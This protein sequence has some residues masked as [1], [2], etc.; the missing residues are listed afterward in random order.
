VKCDASSLTDANPSSVIVSWGESGEVSTSTSLTAATLAVTSKERATFVVTVS[1]YANSVSGNALAMDSSGIIYVSDQSRIKKITPQGVLSGEVMT[2]SG[3]NSQGFA[4]GQGTS[5]QFYNP[6][7]IAVDSFGNLIVA[8]K[9]NKRI[10]K[11][12]PS[13]DV[14]T[15][16][17]KNEG[18]ADG[19]GTS[20]EFR[21]P[22]D[23]TIDATGNI[24]VTDNQS[25]RKISLSYE[26]ST[27]A[28]SD[29]AS[30]Y[31]DSTGT[32][33]RFNFPRGIASD[34]LG[35]VFVA[36]KGNNRIR[37]ITPSRV[38]T[39]L[40]GTGNV[41]FAD[42]AGTNAR[43]NS[44]IG[45]TFFDGYLIVS[46][47]GNCRIRKITLAGV[48]T[49]LAGRGPCGL[50]DGIGKDARF[51]DPSG[52][53]FVS[54][55]NIFVGERS[56]IRKI[57]ISTPLPVPLPVC[58]ST[59]HH[60]ALTYSG[61]SSTNTLN[62]YIDGSY[63]AY[64]TSTYAITSSDASILRLGSSGGTYSSDFFTGS[65][66]DLRI[67][68]RSLSSTEIHSLSRP[69]PQPYSAGA[70]ELLPYTW[71]CLP[72]YYGSSQITLT[73]SSSD[74]SWSSASGSL[75][76]CT[77][78]PPNT[79]NYYSGASSC[80]SCPFGSSLVSS[81]LGCRPTLSA[82]PSDTSFYLSGTETEGVASF[83]FLYTPS[84][85]SFVSNVFG[86]ANGALNLGGNSYLL[87]PGLSAPPPLP[88]TGNVEWTVS[89]WVRCSSL[90][91][92]ATIVEW[93]QIESG[94]IFAQ[95]NV[96]LIVAGVG[97]FSLSVVN[98]EV[99]SP[100]RLAVDGLGNIF[101]A[102]DNNNAI[103][104]ITPSGTF[105]I[106]D[107]GL[108]N[109]NG[110]SVDA[111][112]TVYVADTDNHAIK[113]ISVNGAVTTIGSG[114]TY[115]CGV[116]VDASGI[117]FVADT[118][119][120]AIK[121]ITSFGTTTILDIGLAYPRG[122]DV[123]LSG[124][125]YIA[126]T[127]NHAI[128]KISS[129]GTVTTLSTGFDHPYDIALDYIG[130]IYVADTY[131]HAI[132]KITASGSVTLVNTG[133]NY[134]SGID[135]DSFGNVYVAD[136]SNNA[137]K[138]CVA[139]I[140]AC[141]S[142]WHHISQSYSSS[143][144]IL[145]TSIDGDT[146][147]QKIVSVSLP[148][149]S[150]STF[151][152]GWS[153]ERFFTGSLYDLRI[154][155][156][157]LSSTEIH[158]LSRPVP[159]PY[160]AGAFE[161]LPYTWSCLPGYYGSSQITL[162]RS[163]SDGSWSSASGSLLSCTVCPPNT[164]NYYSGASSCSSCPFGSSLVS[165]TLGCR[166]T[167]S[168]GPSDTSFYLSGTETE[169]V[170]A[171][172][173]TTSSMNGISSY[174][175]SSSSS[176]PSS[177]LVFSSG[178]YLSTSMLSSLPVGSSPF[179][180]SSWVKCDASSLTDAN[181]SSV[182]VSWGESGEVST[183][184]S[185]TAATLAVTSSVRLNAATTP[186]PGPLPVCDSTWHHI[187][188][189]Y[190][191]SS[192]SSSTLTAYV[193]GAG[194]ASIS[195]TYAITSSS[196]STLRLGS[197]G[198]TTTS[199]FY[200]GTISDVRIY[201]HSLSNTEISELRLPPPTP[202]ASA[203]ATASSRPSTSS[204]PSA[205]SSASATVSVS[206]KVTPSTTVSTSSTSSVTATSTVTISASS[207]ST[208][209]ST[210]TQSMSVTPT[211]TSSGTGSASH[212]QSAT[213]SQS[214]NPTMTPSTTVSSSISVT[215]SSLT[216]STA[217]LSSQASVTAVGSSIGTSS[218]TT[219]AT[220]TAT[221]TTSGTSTRSGT[222]TATRA[223]VD[224]QSS[225][226]SPRPI[227]NVAFALSNVQ[228]SL[229]TASSE[230]SATLS[231]LATAVS[232]AAGVSSSF[233]SIR[234]VRDMTF[235]L[236]PV[237]IWINPQFAGDEFPARRRLQGG[238]SSTGSVG[239]DVQINVPNTAA[240]STLSS[241]LASTSTKLATDVH[242]SLVTQGS[243][244]SSATISAKVEVFT[245]ASK[246]DTNKSSESIS[247]TAIAYPA[248]MAFVLVAAAI[249]IGVMYCKLIRKSQS[250]IAIAPPDDNYKKS[251]NYHETEMS[252]ES[253]DS[254]DTSITSPPHRTRPSSTSPKSFQ[255]K[256]CGNCGFK[257]DQ[258]NK[259]CP[260]C[261]SMRH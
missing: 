123:D 213:H 183:S 63:K 133:L 8:D 116:K 57:T 82:G 243:P 122:V 105:S 154:Y 31:A 160:S 65:L 249:A 251:R 191:G 260:E 156:R 228:L 201:S 28:G 80:S 27:I 145:S 166:P 159:Q 67:Y 227:V 32:D 205:S 102:E 203:S 26:V 54:Q 99:S 211:M 112:G 176:F 146:V 22:I 128:K 235:P 52:L 147:S 187:A 255:Y 109:P 81:T 11:L 168:A 245:A 64:T 164:Y 40:A 165:S 190:S 151:R 181:P 68:S 53:A 223:Q 76:S 34:S 94:W 184:T 216:T 38:V 23:V 247:I 232:A 60:I 143:S 131:N 188:L 15:I 208:V 178:S 196:I 261:G 85:I 17:G 172:S 138:I 66:Y 25:I 254:E 175:P 69:V 41:G 19:S 95:R 152:V 163:S 155:S 35:N 61:S 114:F 212:S 134:P 214:T 197:N 224:L 149:L 111:I 230:Q 148:P 51:D 207:S 192:S 253:L 118:G 140:P 79:Y 259:F 186:L 185:L 115:P 89:A 39:T 174:I 119:N 10:R 210:S 240:A 96:A 221:G 14:T 101:V 136:T 153:S 73:R 219:S 141:D 189:T 58:D 37:K 83:P 7:G 103:K 47:H 33:A 238:A 30:G 59:W 248:A 233:V 45:I 142:T 46:D 252:V 18:A 108:N 225:T 246:G 5:A 4:D 257:F 236:T 43:F 173:A 150:Q 200:S 62:A 161:L 194:V 117:V 97:V 157:S 87:L 193:D 231:S 195:A 129:S 13:G 71:S 29:G 215:F 180:V 21:A 220:A 1:S 48:V 169:G 110:V 91:S 49:T 144:S 104:K 56:R 70:F 2:F 3:Q 36:D 258:S 50:A 113:V 75:L 6:H 226:P 90:S 100:R 209:S 139:S 237:V 107:S 78:C 55:N 84:A 158:S 132:K 24:F 217:S 177:G 198:G 256:F 202:S 135:A 88:S 42:G 206:S 106:L 92:V 239:I 86:L 93:G 244:L 12:T 162:T 98:N 170:A 125:V 74:G 167:L 120:H 121:K 241:S 9:D 126:D 137:I 218:S 171:F 182:I 77:V 72:G 20:A 250:V 179:S 127:N 124:N 44:P 16:A 130:N 199:E 234:R 222:T 242:Q 204:Q 229:F